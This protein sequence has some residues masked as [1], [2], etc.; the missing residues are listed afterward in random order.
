[1]TCDDKQTP[2]EPS[3]A[4]APGEEFPLAE[5]LKPQQ[6]LDYAAIAK[7]DTP[8][9]EFAKLNEITDLLWLPGGLGEYA[10]EARIVKALDQV[11]RDQAGRW[12]RSLAGHP[13]DRHT[14][15]G[16]GM[17]AAGDAARTDR[18]GARYGIEAC[19]EAHD[20]VHAAI[21]GARQAP[22]QG[23]AEDHD[24]AGQR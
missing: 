22:R 21:G 15:G 23:S 12:S 1:M 18:R 24:R 11:Q 7:T 2:V 14:R 10:R 5:R 20:A 6:L 13:D 19:P 9:G 16:R 3:G 4:E 17:P 8:G